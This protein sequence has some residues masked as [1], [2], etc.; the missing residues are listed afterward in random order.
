MILTN[1]F[2][3]RCS[4]I[5]SKVI[6]ISHESD[7]FYEKQCNDCGKVTSHGDTEQEIRVYD[8]LIE[9]VANGLQPYHSLYLKKHERIKV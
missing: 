2:K 5:N 1:L 8:F 7:R 9:A 6:Y 4:H 3:K